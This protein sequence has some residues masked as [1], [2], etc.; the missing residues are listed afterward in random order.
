LAG[1][2]NINSRCWI[3]HIRVARDYYSPAQRGQ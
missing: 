2:F 3:F 1:K